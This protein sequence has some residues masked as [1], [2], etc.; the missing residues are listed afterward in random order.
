MYVIKTIDHRKFIYAS[1]HAPAP[2][3]F[4]SK[5]Q[6]TSRPKHSLEVSGD[7]LADEEFRNLFYLTMQKHSKLEPRL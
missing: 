2:E 4:I 5:L 1:S 7:L 6:K 3:H